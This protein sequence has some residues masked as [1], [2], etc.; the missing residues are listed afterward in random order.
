MQYQVTWRWLERYILQQPSLQSFAP[1][2]SPTSGGHNTGLGFF[3]LMGTDPITLQGLLRSMWADLGDTL[4]LQYT[5]A[6][7][8]MGATLRQ[9]GHTARAMLEK[10]WRAMNRAYCEHFEDDARQSAIQLLL[11]SHKLPKAPSASELR[12]SP[13]GKLLLA[14]TSWNLHGRTPW[15]SSQTLQRLISGACQS[16]RPDVFVFCFQEFTELSAANVVMLGCG[17]ESRQAKFDVAAAAALR[18]VLGETYV[19]VRAVGMVGLLA[20]AFV[21]APLASS[22]RSVTGE[23]VRSGLYGQA[24]NKGAVVVSFKVQETSICVASVHL[25]SGQQIKKAQERADQLREILQSI[26]PPSTDKGPPG[27][28]HDLV[29]VSGDFNFRASFPD[30]V[31]PRGLRQT[32][33]KGWVDSESG[34]VGEGA[35]HPGE[36]VLRLFRESDEMASSANGT[37]SSSRQLQDLLK[38]HSLMEG[39]VYFPPTYRWME[40]Q[41]AYD[42]E[43]QPAWCD[44]VLHSKVSVARKSYCALGG[45]TQSDHRP[46]CALLEALLLAMPQTVASPSERTAT[47]LPSSGPELPDLLS[48]SVAEPTS[49]TSISPESSPAVREADVRTQLPKA[50]DKPTPPQDLLDLDGSSG[51]ACLQA[52]PGGSPYGWSPKVGQLVHARYQDGW[53]FAN[54]TRSGN[55]TVDVAWLRP[56]GSVWG[57]KAEMSHYLCSTSAD[58]T[59]HGD[60]LPVSTH[61]R[62]PVGGSLRSKGL[63]PS[64]SPSFGPEVDLLG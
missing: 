54:V 11:R 22:V 4:S 40:G 17:D 50:A 24:G 6:A 59:Q 18:E 53:F 64:T 36:D 37:S 3:D 63:H 31:D 45:F 35:A 39:P 13:Q 23:R 27:A 48:D 46:V 28:K 21:A 2:V 57:D 47:V 44:R 41:A 10:G 26:C 29:V 42:F 7:S 20:A 51:P 1:S 38:E 49:N 33:A 5:G 55:G 14:V 9:G 43:R 16:S 8:T 34:R 25:E 60:K 56:Q 58:E 30:G 52:S 62:P 32:L 15:E 61:V 19:P 12:R